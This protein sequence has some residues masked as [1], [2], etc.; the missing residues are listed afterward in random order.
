MKSAIRDGN[1]VFYFENRHLHQ[2]REE[3]PESE[4]LIPNW[5]GGR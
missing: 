4:Y 1:P 2:V 3:V 5:Q